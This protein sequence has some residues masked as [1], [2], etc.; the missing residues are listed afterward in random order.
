MIKTPA[1]KPIKIPITNPTI[2]GVVK[3]PEELAFVSIESNFSQLDVIEL[4][5]S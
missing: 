5:S 3:S 1:I 2:N 4:L